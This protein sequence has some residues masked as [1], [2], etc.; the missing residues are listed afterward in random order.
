[1]TVH[2]LEDNLLTIDKHTILFV[3]IVLMTILDGAESKFL[4]FYMDSL[5]SSISQSKYS[6]IEIGLLCIPCLYAFGAEVYLG[7]IAGNRV[8]G[9][10][11][12]FLPIVVND[13]NAYRTANHSPIKED[14]CHK[15]SVALGINC[16]PLDVLCRL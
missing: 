3:A 2:A 15:A 12:H 5:S 7:A 4:T 13:I 10:L 6:C 14:I 1:M 11:S 16:Y 8:G 9:T